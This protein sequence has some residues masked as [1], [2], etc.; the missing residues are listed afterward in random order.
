MG[1]GYRSAIHD[2]DV[3]R[4]RD[5]MTRIPAL[6]TA[7]LATAL[8]LASCAPAAAPSSDETDPAVVSA[9]P[10]PDPNANGGDAAWSPCTGANLDTL[11]SSID[12]GVVQE[13]PT[14]GTYPPYMPNPSCIAYPTDQGIS[15]AFF[16]GATTDDYG[17]MEQSIVAEQG[18]G[19]P[20]GDLSDTLLAD[21]TWPS[22]GV[23]DLRFVPA[24]NGID[25]DRIEATSVVANYTPGG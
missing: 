16:L 1:R 19:G 22:G 8:L 13:A 12:G 23:I 6:I 5:R 9:T 2:A 25:V 17:V 4:Y 21:E 10:T 7:S 18:P 24:G 11:T 14:D 15:I 3:Q 20:G